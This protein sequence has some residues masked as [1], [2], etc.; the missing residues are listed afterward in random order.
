[1]TA[2]RAAAARRFHSRAAAAR[3][4]SIRR[5]FLP[6]TSC[7]SLTT[8]SIDGVA[9]VLGLVVIAAVA[10]V[11]APVLA[12][13]GGGDLV[14]QA[15][16]LVPVEQ[17]LEHDAVG[18]APPFQSDAEL[19][20]DVDGLAAGGNGMQRALTRVCIALFRVARQKTDD[21]NATH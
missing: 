7:P 12:W 11:L 16:V 6:Q 2:S 18:G 19:A 20:R 10:L 13:R 14:G 5:A 1:M 9:R 17:R 15:V 3:L 4:R 8:V 21:A